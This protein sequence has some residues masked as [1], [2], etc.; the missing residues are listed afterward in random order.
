MAKSLVNSSQYSS[1][2]VC[3]CSTETQQRQRGFRIT[4]SGV[5]FAPVNV[6]YIVFR[7]KTYPQA[8]VC[9]CFNK[10]NY[11]TTGL[12]SRPV[13]KCRRNEMTDANK[14]SLQCCRPFSTQLIDTCC[15]SYPILIVKPAQ[16][17]SQ[18]LLAQPL[19]ACQIRQQILLIR[20]ATDSFSIGC[21]IWR[22]NHTKHVFAYLTERWKYI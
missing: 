2:R 15:G 20:P 3:G 13:S 7:S 17:L 18:W 14:I 12:V 9:P 22:S 8:S 4:L 6:F 19:C 16:W 5:I 10:Q 21:S 11:P 1:Y